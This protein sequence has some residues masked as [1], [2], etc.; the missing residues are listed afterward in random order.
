MSCNCHK[1]KK[2]IQVADAIA[3]R[4]CNNYDSDYDDLCYSDDDKSASKSEIT[5]YFCKRCTYKCYS[6]DIIGCKNCI[7][8]VCC[9]CCVSMCEKCRNNGDSL[10]GCYGKCYTCGRDVNRGSEGWPC[11]ECKKWYCGDCRYFDENTCSDCNPNESDNESDND[12][13]EKDK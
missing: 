11:Y 13:K 7:D 4:F 3:C 12:E 2:E 9:D 1:C 5:L 6:C 10:C 8:T